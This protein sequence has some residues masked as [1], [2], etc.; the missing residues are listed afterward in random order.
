MDDMGRREAEESIG[1]L[2]EARLA[3]GGKGA[4][5]LDEAR[6]L[7]AVE[8]SRAISSTIELDDLLVFTVDSLVEFFCAERGF[9]LLRVEGGFRFAVARDS[10]GKTLSDPE[11]KISFS[12]VNEVCETGESIL[13]PRATEHPTFGDKSSVRKLELQSVMCV[14]ML[15]RDET[16]GAIYLD[17][18][19]QPERF[20]ASDERM[21]RIAA[22]HAAA[23]V[24]NA[25]LF[26]QLS[27]DAELMSQIRL[28]DGDAARSAL[29]DGRADVAA[30]IA[31]NLKWALREI[32]DN[33]GRLRAR[34]TRAGD[35]V[36]LGADLDQ[37]ARIAN[38]AMRLV[39]DTERLYGD[40]EPVPMRR[41]DLGK[42]LSAAVDG[43]FAS[44][45]AMNLDAAE[46]VA[47][48]RSS[49][50]GIWVMADESLLTDAL[51]RIVLNSIEAMPGGGE[52]RIALTRREL[53]A[54]IRISD[55][56]IGMPG[57]SGK[58][59]DPL[60]MARG[61]RQSGLSLSVVRGAI[62]RLGGA[63]SAES[64]AGTGT[65]MSI[66]VRLPIAER[67][68]PER[69]GAESSGLGRT[70]LVIEDRRDAAALLE[71]LLAREGFRVVA[72]GS[73]EQA[74][75]L[76]GERRTDAILLD[77]NDAG[78]DLWGAIARLRAAFP[79]A[80]IIAAA[81]AQE[82]VPPDKA[83]A[84]GADMLIAKPLR[85]QQIMEALTRAISEKTSGA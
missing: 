69:D 46:S 45:K 3:L 72:A 38:A 42:V 84:R 54:E 26:R 31:Q 22:N 12:V 6:L 16:I 48:R 25:R 83:A 47:I 37:I 76:R 52:L 79:D 58:T 75:Q 43:A 80:A 7:K 17:A 13:I 74:V 73:V 81:T 4:I 15:N 67:E 19:T 44:A 85:L 78:R 68:R 10:R 77:L 36:A 35:I 62:R 70:A 63:I 49:D 57:S 11:S 8:L 27:R 53:L 50:T 1:P 51:S 64:G 60:H 14:P 23:A 34:E 20:D 21:C 32:M 71:R 39:D 61:N 18:P 82:Q 30:G 5:N 29:A 24:E 41:C 9:L 59:F 2:A 55:T 66:A 56:G 28:Q 40:T 33:I 65:G